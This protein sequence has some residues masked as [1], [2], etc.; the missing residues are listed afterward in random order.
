[1]KYKTCPRC[2]TETMAKKQLANG[3]F[4]WYCQICG[5]KRGEFLKDIKKGVV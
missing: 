1:M 4:T 2:G 5:L 3:K